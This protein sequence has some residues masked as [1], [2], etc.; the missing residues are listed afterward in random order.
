M[1]CSGRQICEHEEG[2]HCVDE[3]RQMQNLRNA[4]FQVCSSKF[5]SVAYNYPSPSEHYFIKKFYSK[6]GGYV[7]NQGDHMSC[8]VLTPRV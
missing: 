2:H 5:E 8:F 7:D 4:G 6:E 3:E 1:I